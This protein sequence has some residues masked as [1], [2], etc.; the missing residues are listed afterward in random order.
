M[1]ERITAIAD[2][3]GMEYVGMQDH[4]YN[5]GFYDTLTVI[6]R[7]ASRTRSVH[8]FPN[9]ANLALRPPVM[10]AKQAATIDAISGGRFELGLG[11]GAFVDA[12]AG[13][14]GSRRSPAQARAA[15]AEA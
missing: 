10:L 9:V 15:L 7:L 6:T 1:A 11:S 3:N 14:G 4:P 8:L 13:M 5:S 2:E 12:I